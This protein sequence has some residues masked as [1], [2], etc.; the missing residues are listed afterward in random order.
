MADAAQQPQQSQQQKKRV[1]LSSPHMG[2]WEQKY[3]AEAFATN[4][5]APVGPHVQAFEQEFCQLTAAAP[6]RC[7]WPFSSWAWGRGTRCWSAR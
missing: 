1:Y 2:E 3:V 4:W 6:G 7:T 5:V